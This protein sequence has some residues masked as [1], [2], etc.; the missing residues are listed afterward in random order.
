MSERC[1]GCGGPIEEWEVLKSCPK[2]KAVYHKDCYPD[3][4]LQCSMALRT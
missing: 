4:C 3:V 1:R 2:C